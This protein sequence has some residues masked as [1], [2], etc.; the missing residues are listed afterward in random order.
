MHP[1]DAEVA[2]EVL[3]DDARWSGTVEVVA[4]VRVAPGGCVLE[5]GDCR[6][7]AQIAPALDRLRQTLTP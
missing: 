2:R 6:I 7:D 5:V 3:R 4:D 1:D